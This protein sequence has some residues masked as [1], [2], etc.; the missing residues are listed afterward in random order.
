MNPEGESHHYRAEGKDRVQ[1]EATASLQ[2]GV[3]SRPRRKVGPER[4]RTRVRHVPRASL[5]G[6]DEACRASGESVP[7]QRAGKRG[8]A[9]GTVHQQWHNHYF[10]ELDLFSLTQAQLLARQSR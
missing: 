2:S 1:S 7:V 6:K 3:G 10:T 8:R 9:R 4:K 5:R